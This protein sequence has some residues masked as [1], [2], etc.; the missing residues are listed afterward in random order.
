MA[1]RMRCFSKDEEFICYECSYDEDIWCNAQK[2]NGGIKIDSFCE[3]I[4]PVRQARNYAKHILRMCDT[5]DA[6]KEARRKP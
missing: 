4:L 1:E 5:I 2:T 6:E 3:P